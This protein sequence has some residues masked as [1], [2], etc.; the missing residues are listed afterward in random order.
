MRT[1]TLAGLT[2]AFMSLTACD[3]LP[4]PD[5]VLPEDLLPEDDGDAGPNDPELPSLPEDDPVVDEIEAFFADYLQCSEKIRPS[6]IERISDVL[7]DPSEQTVVDLVTSPEVVADVVAQAGIQVEATV[8]LLRNLELLYGEGHAAELLSG[9]WESL[10]CDDTITLACTQGSGSSTAL[11]SSGSAVDSV[12]FDLDA[13]ILQGTKMEGGVA[14]AARSANGIGATVTFDDLIFDEVDLIAGAVSLDAQAGSSAKDLALD[15]GAQLLLE[16]HGGPEGAS[17][18]ERTTLDTFV[19]S[20]TASS[21]RVE[22]DG[23]KESADSRYA[24]R[25][26]GEHLNFTPELDCACPTPGSGLEMTF[27]QPFA[28]TDDD[29][30]VRINY[31]P[32]NDPE[33]CA[34]VSVTIVEWPTDCA[35][36]DGIP[37]D[38]GAESARRAIGDLLEPFCTTLD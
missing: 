22:L 17:C 21:L 12:A 1:F 5:D 14:F 9:G 19:V 10:S 30:T 15:T 4:T 32:A 36:V 8:I 2:L 11:C 29:A 33:R 26:V 28:D 37:D 16:A 34:S 20:A 7:H 13:C 38:C 3:S 25:T 23:E 18:G 6:T 31:G 35:L 24:L 27:P